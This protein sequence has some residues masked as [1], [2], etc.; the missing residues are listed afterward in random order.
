MSK[1][2]ETL[3]LFTCSKPQPFCRLGNRPKTELPCTILN[4]DLYCIDCV[5]STEDGSKKTIDLINKSISK[6]NK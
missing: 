3:M 6:E 1:Y 4:S 2:I 5:F